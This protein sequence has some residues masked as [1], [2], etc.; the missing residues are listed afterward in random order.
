MQLEDLFY[1]KNQLMN[2]LLTNERIVELLCSDN[3]P[4]DDP[5]DLMYTQ[6]FPYEYIPETVEHGYTFICCDIDIQRITGKTFLDPV[7]YIWVFSH[8]S[9]MRL[10]EGGVRTDALMAEIA[11]TIN[12]SRDYGLGELDLYSVRRYAPT[13][14]YNGKQM[15]FH[16][17]EF[18]KPHPNNHSVPA[19]RR[20]G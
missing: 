13:T 8:R 1:Y 5:A 6:L 4:V 18:N 12:G 15:T 7:M 19:N 20:T 16:A 3:Q 10:P 2:D 14:E 9:K 11:K 17:T